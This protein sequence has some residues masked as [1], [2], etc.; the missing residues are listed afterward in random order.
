MLS[1]LGNITHEAE[2][3]VEDDGVTQSVT[4]RAG[5]ARVAQV[6]LPNPVTLQPYR[7]FVEVEQPESQFVLRI[8]ADPENKL[9]PIKCAL[10]PADG[11]RW[12]AVAA[13]NIKEWLEVSIPF[14]DFTLFCLNN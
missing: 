11:N 2:I 10:F 14:R 7:T 8:K 6:D 12:K 4:A 9:E 13:Q 1:I 5:I 3:R